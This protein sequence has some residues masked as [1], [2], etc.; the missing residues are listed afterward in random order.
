MGRTKTLLEEGADPNGRDE[1]GTPA[2][3]NA[4]LYGSAAHMKLLIDRGAGVNARNP[5]DATALLW[6]AG[7]PAKAQMLMDK[8]ADVN[9]Q[10]K[11][12]R[13]PLMVAASVAGNA[14]TVKTMLAKGARV[15]VK[16]GISPIP[17]VPAGGGKGTPLMDAA[18]T[19][20]IDTVALLL[21]AG[22]DV[23][24]TDARNATALSEAVMYS[25]R[26][27]VRMLLDAGADATGSITPLQF[28]YME[29]AAMRGD[30]PVAQ[31]LLR[32]KAPL[33]MADAAG[34]TPLMFAAASD[35]DNAAMV[36]FLIEAGAEP[37]A[38]NRARETALDW[39]L[40]RGQKTAIVAALKSAG[41][42]TGA[43]PRLQ[44]QGEAMGNV[45]AE[46]AIAKALAVLG[47]ASKASFQTGG[48]A[49][50]HNHTLPMVASAVAA[51]KGVA[52]DTGA[53]DMMTRFTASMLAPMTEVLLEG[54]GVPPDMAVSGGYLL[55]AL[56]A[57]KY[58]ANRATASVVHN[59]AQ[60][61]MADGR[62]VGWAPRGPLE[63][64]DIQ[65]TAMS[66]RSLRMYPIPGRQAEMEQR[67]ARAQRWLMQ[68]TPANTEEYIMRLEGLMDSGAG[69]SA[70]TDASKQ[71][72]A[73]QRAD[74]GWGQLPGL[75][76]DAYATGKA[77]VALTRARATA[78]DR[79]A[80][81]AW[82]RG[83]QQAD[84]SWQVTTRAFPFQPLKDTGFPHGRDQ[85]ISA[86]GTSWAAMAL[87]M[88]MK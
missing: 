42:E 62:W 3:M 18:R 83:A 53:V 72:A 13:T 70:V 58:A 55:E 71:L 9:A 76:S 33:N 45:S 59:V 38:K 73:L 12:G 77:V 49:N 16:D 47:K 74:G 65:A 2:L 50:C 48:C 57:Q 41:A 21:E 20:D 22:A 1:E 15:N 44:L 7:D 67:I 56:R 66:I 37:N 84:G 86:A 17:V 28:S 24:A 43:A 6:A 11:L 80:A 88:N 4:A 81:I 19:G 8:G 31:M 82:L 36:S 39:A 60:M 63:A 51:R 26:A 85:W 27:V 29:L 25:R 79:K 46:E 23:H 68:A 52:V 5:M 64:G 34:N 14:A 40:R 10:S 61:Q 30:V 69:S 78:G 32:H 54:S 87:A 35:R 75:P